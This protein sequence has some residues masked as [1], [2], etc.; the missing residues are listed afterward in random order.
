MFLGLDSSTQSLT[1]VVID[2]ASGRIV[3]QDSVNFGESFMD[4]GCPNGFIPGGKDGEVHSNPLMWLDALD[5]LFC[6][7]MTTI[8]V[9]RIRM[10]AG[11]GQQHGSVY[12]GGDFEK[13]VASL[14]Y[15]RSLSSQLAPTLTR[16]TSPIWMDTSTGAECREI[17]AAVGGDAEVC[18]RSGSIAIERFTG[19][20]IRRFHKLQPDAYRATA[21][22]HLVSSF[23]ASVLAG[24]I[25]PIDHGDGAGMNL[26]DLS[27]LRWDPGLLDATAPGLAGKLPP[28]APATTVQ[29]AIS[30]YFVDK[31]GFSDECRCALFT[32]DNPASLVGMG[33]TKPGAVVI[34]LGTSDTFFAA[35]PG[36]KTDPN[37]F[38]HVFGNPAGGFMSLICFRNGSLAREA[39]RDRLGL[40]WSDFDQPAL[41][42]TRHAAGE[43][44]ML[45]FFGP[46]IT[47]RRD[48]STPVLKGSADFEGGNIPGL[49]VRALLEG[50]FLNMR[51]HSRWMEVP[52]ERIRL[53]GGA[54]KNNGI[55]TLVA[56]V[57]QAPVERLDVSNSAALGAALIAAAADGHPLEALQETFCQSQ[58]SAIAPD[59]AL[60]PV[61]QNALGRF[62]ALLHG[63]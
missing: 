20:Q 2:P 62:E 16:A 26:L 42:A 34:S 59:P 37:G 40:D 12:L 19:P 58:G 4:Y 11:S 5:L 51:L 46:E 55:A 7:L 28:T 54:S 60:G 30:R 10:I 25:A 47:P 43:N 36:A 63:V 21:Q 27:T 33:A 41:E 6:R 1:A 57:F 35:M 48:F 56:N 29:G 17:A 8:D 45:P 44:L 53:T 31:F 39:L 50:Q 15:R 38:G 14:D 13:T 9:S 18:R 52:V 22:I 32:G 3:H 61:Y 49:Q 24:R 23:I